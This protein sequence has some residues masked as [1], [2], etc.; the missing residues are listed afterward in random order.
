MIANAMLLAVAVAAQ[1]QQ[2]G[3]RDL[4]LNGDSTAL[5]AEVRRRPADARELLGRLIEQAARPS[6]KPDSILQIAERIARA[7]V[8]TWADSFPLTNL[9]R[10]RRLSPTQ[11]NA[12]RLADSVR[13]AG[14]RVSTTSGMRMAITI[15]RQALRRSAAVPDTAGM[16]AAMGNIGAGLYQEA[17]LDS[18]EAYLNAAA[19]LA[20]FVGDK[21]TQLNAFGTLGALAM[22]RGELRRADELLRHSLVLRLLIGD[23]RGAAADHTNLGLIAADL[24][25][26]AAARAHHREAGAIAKQHDLADAEATALLN[27]ANLASQA[28]EYAEAESQYAA[29][30]SLFR[31]AGADADVGLV[32]HNQGLLSLRRGDYRRA[33]DRL[34]QALKIFTRAGTAA[35]IVQVRRDLAAL[36][37]ATGN[38]RAA[39]EQLRLAERA[40][41]DAPDDDLAGAVALA[42][43]DLATMLN[44]HV[45]ADQHYVAAQTHYQR[46][47]NSLGDAEARQGRAM[48]L[49]ERRL[50]ARALDLLRSAQRLQVASGDRRGAALTVLSMGHTYQR[51]DSL[52]AARRAFTQALDTLRALDDAAGEAAA[53]MAL[54]EMELDAGAHLAAEAGYRRALERLGRDVTPMLTWQARAG[55]GRALW[56][57]RTLDEAASELRAAIADLERTAQT[58][59][60]AERRASYLADKWD[61][62]GDL[63]LVERARGRPDSAFAVGERMRARQMIELLSRGRID[64]GRVAD[65]ALLAREQDARLRVADLSRRLEQQEGAAR[66]LRG[67]ELVGAGSGVTRE[68]LFRAQEQYAQLLLE[69]RDA[70]GDHTPLTR[71]A[72]EWRTVAQRLGSKQAMISYL[73]S[74]ATTLA[75]VIRPDTMAVVDLAIGRRA[76]ATLVDFARGTIAAPPGGRVNQPWRAPLR[77]LYQQLI[78]PIE[79]AGLL[80]ETSQLV[81][82]PHEELHYLPFGA[83]LRSG[84]RDEHLVE[85]Y[86]IGYAPSATAWTQLGDRDTSPARRVLALAPR[87]GQLPGSRDEVEA[88]GRLYGNDAT[89]R[90]GPAATEQFLRDSAQSFGIVHLATYGILNQHNPLFS[91]VDFG[92]SPDTPH[93]RLEVHEVFALELQARLVVLS[94]C[95]T[96]L[97]SGTVADVPSGD[98]WVGLVR[99]FLTAGAA[100]VIATLW[101]VEDR[102]TAAIMTQL[103]RRLRSG[104]SEVVALSRAQ[105]DMLRNP[106]TLS[107]FYWAGFVLVGGDAG[108]AQGRRIDR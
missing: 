21:R 5:A 4:S 69:L 37:L 76:L 73:V 91:F 45:V 89:V 62:F 12:K 27:L 100:N 70:R 39:Q 106:A 28:A 78:E 65:T 77:R 18:A 9:Q 41:S 105:R 86:D 95:Q 68:A 52:A 58:E 81:I 43:A 17:Q 107:P 60:L 97:A 1:Q 26:A 47:G 56:A 2:G 104:E 57:R 13:L 102:S 34:Q 29:A 84:K 48:L 61:V 101:A 85:R 59:L 10:F 46:A 51:A 54:A 108:I 44:T 87:P 82:V 92:G 98:D 50:F 42:R 103:H 55:L 11:R 75:F 90:V 30:L 71:K 36:D 22:D 23:V 79:H 72:A 33:R 49:I 94:A 40:L 8:A 99:A 3:I 14:N 67:P 32:L 25:D 88:I 38:L 7:Y 63:A 64:R 19:N 15:W 66:A 93:H 96:A 53:H 6:A 83:L 74:E 35:D 80:A 31:A 16:A 20:M 24:G